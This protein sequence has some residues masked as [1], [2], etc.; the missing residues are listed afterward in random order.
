MEQ[1]DKS[2]RE[3]LCDR[4]VAMARRIWAGENATRDPKH[5]EP[6]LILKRE[7][8][9]TESQWTRYRSGEGSPMTRVN[10][11]RARAIVS[12]Y[13][14]HQ[15]KDPGS[16]LAIAMIDS[17][18]EA[19][20]RLWQADVMSWYG[21]KFEEASEWNQ[22][23][24]MCQ[25]L[26][27]LRSTTPVSGVLPL[28]YKLYYWARDIHKALDSGSSR[29]QVYEI[30][31]NLTSLNLISDRLDAARSAIS[32]HDPMAEVHNVI[33][34][35]KNEVA[36][37]GYKSFLHSSWLASQAEQFACMTRISKDGIG[38]SESNPGRNA[39]EWRFEFLRMLVIESWAR[40]I[41]PTEDESALA[42]NRL[43]MAWD[44][45]GLDFIRS[46]TPS[47]R[48]RVA[49]IRAT[50]K[51]LIY[52]GYSDLAVQTL[53]ILERA[54]N[55]SPEEFYSSLDAIREK[56]SSG[57]RYQQRT[58]VVVEDLVMRSLLARTRDYFNAY[59]ELAELQISIQQRGFDYHG[60]WIKQILEEP[61]TPHRL[62][63]GPAPSAEWLSRSQ[64]PRVQ[65]DH[66]F[67]GFLE[68]ALGRAPATVPLGAE[69][70]DYPD[71]PA[72][73]IL[74]SEYEELNTLY[75]TS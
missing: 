17:D 67:L 18:W 55:D 64:V 75:A 62:V 11:L 66:P 25:L 22:L 65:S 44:F 73:P 35:F 9:L 19:L 58:A 51:L 72:P 13:H 12:L 27:N 29:T 8:G 2:A 34:K 26:D 42:L 33:V 7:L 10:F 14:S 50:I 3:Q 47:S 6:K 31:A 24:R 52:L 57:V 68:W 60:R 49:L 56:D 37:G 63:F 53:P 15:F 69:L 32:P 1:A 39:I 28:A 43:H 71:R 23:Q 4:L 48:Y 38:P 74:M 36:C 20:H 30:S 41:H 21:L 40:A 16:A 70:L 61:N 59:D 45:T 5:A 54:R 46:W